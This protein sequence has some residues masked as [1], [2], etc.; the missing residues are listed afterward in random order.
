MK[1]AAIEGDEMPLID[2]YLQIVYGKTYLFSPRCDLSG[3]KIQIL[4]IFFG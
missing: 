3:Q 2:S 4:T 1:L